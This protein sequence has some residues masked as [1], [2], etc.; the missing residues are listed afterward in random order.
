MFGRDQSW[1]ADIATTKLVSCKVEA[2]ERPHRSNKLQPNP[3]L[4]FRNI[5]KHKTIFSNI[6]TESKSDV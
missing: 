2:S 6:H 1:V 4:T 5:K 3:Y